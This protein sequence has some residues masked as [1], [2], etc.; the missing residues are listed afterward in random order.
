ML[1]ALVYSLLR[2]F[3]DV[4]DVRLRVRDPEAE[5]LLLRHQLRVVRRQVKRPQLDVADRAIMAALSHR[6]KR[7]AW[8]GMLV[9]PANGPRL[10][11]PTCAQKV[12]GLWPPGRS[13][14]T[15]SRSPAAVADPDN[16]QG[17]PEMGLRSH[18]RR[19]TQARL[20]G[21]RNCDPH[22]AAPE[23]DRFGAVALGAELEDVL[24]SPGFGDRPHRLL[25]R[26]HRIPEAA[27]RPLMYGAGH[28]EGDLVRGHRSAGRVLGQ[29]AGEE[30]VLGTRRSRSRSPVPGS[31][32]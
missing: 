1:F 31:R 19:V 5:L 18:P 13:G 26:R 24:K 4:A 30:R 15:R 16:C 11:S 9:Q 32:S 17:Q 20:R 6:V 28:Q 25:Q 3:L 14:P 22:V 23:P 21:F 8:V 12:G 29:P 27:L 2:L 10:A 7:A